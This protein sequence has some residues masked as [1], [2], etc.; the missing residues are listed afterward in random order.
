MGFYG[1]VFPVSGFFWKII[2]EQIMLFLWSQKYYDFHFYLNA[3]FYIPPPI[4]C[5]CQDYFIF[6][7]C[8]CCAVR[9]HPPSPTSCVLPLRI[10]ASNPFC[11]STP[12]LLE[13]NFA[14]QSPCQKFAVSEH[15]ATGLTVRMVDA[16]FLPIALPLGSGNFCIQRAESPLCCYPQTSLHPSTI[17]SAPS[18]II[19]YTSI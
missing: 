12:P 15:L 18:H 6:S 9:T 16:P 1:R 10:S 5:L 13:A 17:A 4:F 19:W 11:L 14:T 8:I 7:D 3:I 2:K